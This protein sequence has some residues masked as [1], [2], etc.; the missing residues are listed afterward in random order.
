MAN[1]QTIFQ[2]TTTNQVQL[3]SLFNTEFHD[4]GALVKVYVDNGPANTKVP[5]QTIDL[6]K[7][8]P[9]EK[10]DYTYNN[11]TLNGTFSIS[12]DLKSVLFTGSLV[13]GGLM[14]IVMSEVIIANQ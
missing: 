14:N 11:V 1:L 12:D 6:P 8:N 2:G 3:S 13:T 9:T 10:I 7:F 5:V 4:S